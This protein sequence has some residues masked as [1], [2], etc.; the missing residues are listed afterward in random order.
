MST[1]SDGTSTA[2]PVSTQDLTTDELD[3]L[4]WDIAV[5]RPT[6]VVLDTAKKRATF[7]AVSNKIREAVAGNRP[8][9]TSGL[10]H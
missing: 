2:D 1:A 8:S 7:F 10:R 3:D 4:I 5:G 6:R 9:G